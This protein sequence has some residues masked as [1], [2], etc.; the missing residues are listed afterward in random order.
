[1]NK[2]VDYD[3]LVRAAGATLLD[4]AANPKGA[5]ALDQLIR[6]ALAFLFCRICFSVIAG[7]RR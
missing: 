4:V 5:H 6:Q 1:V 2:R 7:G 3:L